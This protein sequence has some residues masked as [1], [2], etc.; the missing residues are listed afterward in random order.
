M[1][2][3]ILWFR[4]DLRIHDNPLLSIKGAVLP[5]FIFDT[6]ILKELSKEDK[7]VTFIWES[8]TSL[9]Q[10]L[11][12]IGLDLYIFHGTPETIFTQLKPHGFTHIYASGDYDSY[13]KQRDSLVDTII[14]LHLLQDTYLLH[15]MSILKEDQTPYLVFTPFYNKVKKLYTSSLHKAYTKEHQTLI[16]SP[17]TPIDQIPFFT[18]TK[19]A[20]DSMQNQLHSLKTLLPQYKIQRDYLDEPHTSSLSTHLRFGTLSI[21]HLVRVLLE[22]K[23]EGIVTEP[24]FRQLIFR[25]FY[26][27]LLFHFPS[28]ETNNYKFNPVLRPNV[29]GFQALQHAQTG[30]PII[31]AAI[32]E[33]ITTGLM[34]N[35]A[36]MIVASFVTKH[37]QIPWQEGEAFF[38]NYLLDYDKASNILSW[39]WSA[40][41]GIDP[42]P[43][44][45]IFNPYT[46]SKKFDPDAHYIK[47]YLPHLE[48]IAAKHLYNESYL[49]QHPL[50]QTPFP[51]LNHAQAREAFLNEN[52]N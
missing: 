12:K 13:A 28:L 46:Q 31:D 2:K 36:R 39:Q 25:E 48:P 9:K 32:T 52:T 8:L 22:Y 4:R 40:G 30:I 16:P 35:R 10:E 41:T 23:Q 17:I 5:I 7:R 49:H 27:Y 50:P 11:Q 14:P 20:L 38:A 44:F 37:L 51:I 6:H 18:L 1:K 24:F 47:K 21:R 43:Y 29:Q 26:A 45:R 34:H 33:L 3:S 19:H 42:Q 15:P